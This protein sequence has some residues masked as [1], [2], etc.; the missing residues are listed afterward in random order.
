[1]KRFNENFLNKLKSNVEANQLKYQQKDT[2]VGG[3][4]DSIDP[5]LLE[6]YNNISLKTQESNNEKLDF[7][8]AKILYKG[9][10]HLTLAEVADEKLW[11]F[12]T[13]VTHW[14]YMRKRWP[15]EG[16]SGDKRNFILTRYFFKERPFSRN[17]LA[18]LWWFGYITHNTKFEDEFYLTSIMLENED[19][20]IAR[21]ILETPTICR[22][23]KMVEATLISLKELKQNYQIKSR[24]YIRHAARYINLTGSVTLW[25]FLNEKEL[26]NI[27]DD[28]KRNWET[29]HELQL[30]L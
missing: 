24:D 2:L 16:T 28:M 8:N 17:G 4:E 3:F 10:S 11:A 30:T 21:I 25:D 6:I 1:M 9:L 19:Q 23:K 5:G 12:M 18:R 29:S 15:V 14:E 13:H 7:E 22:N 27:I 20:D 26:R